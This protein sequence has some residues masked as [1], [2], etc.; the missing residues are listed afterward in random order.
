LVYRALGEEYIGESK[1]AEL[2]GM[3]VSSFRKERKLE[4]PTQA[5]LAQEASRAAAAN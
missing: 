2:L 5:Q 1:A 4:V 3:S